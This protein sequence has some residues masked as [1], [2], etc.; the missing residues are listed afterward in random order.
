MA[1]NLKMHLTSIDNEIY[2]EHLSFV[3]ID[4]PMD[5]LNKHYKNHFVVLQAAKMYHLYHVQ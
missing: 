4:N 2:H 3:T 5:P 1:I